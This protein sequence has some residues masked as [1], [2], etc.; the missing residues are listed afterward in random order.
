LAAATSGLETAPPFAV[1]EDAVLAGVLLAGEL[2]AGALAAVLADGAELA[3][4]AV[5]ASAL[6]GFFPFFAL[7]FDLLAVDEGA[8]L[9]DS[10]VAAVVSDFALFLDFLPEDFVSLEAAD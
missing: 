6:A 2:A 5:V 7:D 8:A 4:G 10:E 9:A 3:A 1:S